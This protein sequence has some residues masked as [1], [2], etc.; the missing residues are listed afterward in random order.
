MVKQRMTEAV[1]GSDLKTKRWRSTFGAARM[2]YETGVFRQAETLLA[3]AAEMAKELPEHSF[4]VPASE[5]GT[6]AVLLAENRSKEAEKR[7]QKCINSLQNYGDKPHRELLGVAMRFHAQ[8]LAEQGDARGAEK[9]LLESAKILQ[10]VGTE[11]CVQFAYTLCDLCGLYLTQG[12]FAEAEQRITI[13]TEILGT[14]F[15]TDFPE[16]KRA[17]MIYAVC[18]YGDDESRM[19]SVRDGIVQLEYRFGSHHPNLRRALDR[20]FKA[21]EE[22]GDSARLEEAHRRFTVAGAKRK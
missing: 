13:A 7:L 15:G 4:A 2:A 20:Y 12:R 8:A 16:Y 5:I 10:D 11:A 9:E 21:L 19:D 18:L 6:A 14:V 1:T 22:R 3:R 17:D